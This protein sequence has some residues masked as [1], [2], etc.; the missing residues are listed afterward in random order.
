MGVW[1]VEM[2]VPMTVV[3]RVEKTVVGSAS[4]LVHSWV[5]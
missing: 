1:T 4:H 5:E 2:T 3:L